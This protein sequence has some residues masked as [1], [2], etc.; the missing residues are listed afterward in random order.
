MYTMDMGSAFML[1]NI[2]T[3]L[4]SGIN[5]FLRMFNISLIDTIGLERE[6]VRTGL[7]MKC[8][9]I[10]TFINSGILLL[11]TNA[12]LQ[13]SVLSFIPITN[14]YS[15]LTSNWYAD[16]GPTI[17]QAMIIMALF[18]IMGFC[19]FYGMK[20]GF[21][22]LDSGLYCCSKEY[23]T[24]KKTV[25]QYIDLYSGVPYAMHFQYSSIL[26]QVYVSFM[27]GMA[28]PILIP[29]TFMGICVMYVTERFLLAYYHPKPPMFGRELNDSV[30]SMFK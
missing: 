4:V 5:Y 22:F 16:I 2:V 25:K 7:I 12:D 6:D 29:I 11:F 21:R 30:I 23:K 14:Q 13:Y 28:L 17:V 1:T 15:D 8:I 20:V 9:F 26:V 27:Y 18:P 24:K 3:A 19:G 10:T